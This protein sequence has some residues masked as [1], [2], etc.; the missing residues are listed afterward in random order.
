MVAALLVFR[1][2]LCLVW[3]EIGLVVIAL[4]WE[5][6][7]TFLPLGLLVLLAGV[8]VEAGVEEATVVLAASEVVDTGMSFG[9]EMVEGPVAGLTWGLRSSHSGA[10]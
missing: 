10:I 8:A 5:E 3:L 1:G 9:L 6:N 2:C 7:V 4:G